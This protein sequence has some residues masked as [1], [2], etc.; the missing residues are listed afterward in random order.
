MQLQISIV[1]SDKPSAFSIRC[2]P[3]ANF[4]FKSI[5]EPVNV[6]NLVKPNYWMHYSC[7]SDAYTKELQGSLYD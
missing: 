6:N 2:D 5:L 1:N 3:N 4:D 7:V